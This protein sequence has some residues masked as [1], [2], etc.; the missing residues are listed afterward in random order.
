[1]RLGF[2]GLGV[3]FHLVGL[4]DGNTELKRIDGVE[5]Q[6][7]TEQRRSAVDISGL[8]IFQ[9]QTADDQFLQLLFQRDHDDLPLIQKM[10]KAGY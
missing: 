3:E 10:Y 8:D 6:A 5:S 7:I 4:L 9:L 1:M 2:F